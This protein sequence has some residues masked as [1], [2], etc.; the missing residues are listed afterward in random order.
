MTSTSVRR[1]LRIFVRRNTS[2][3]L[4]GPQSVLSGPVIPPPPNGASRS[5]QHTD[6]TNAR[7]R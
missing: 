1:A 3:T 4:R 7:S 6:P 5:R 2:F